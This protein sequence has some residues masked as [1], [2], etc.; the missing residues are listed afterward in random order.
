MDAKNFS[1]VEDFYQRNAYFFKPVSHDQLKPEYGLNDSIHGTPIV[2]LIEAAGL[3][4]HIDTECWTSI[5]LQTKISEI[6]KSFT[7]PDISVDEQSLNLETNAAH[8]SPR[9]FSKALHSF[10][11]W[12]LAGGMPGPGIAD[13]MAIL[14]RNVTLDRVKAAADVVRERNLHGPELEEPTSEANASR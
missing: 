9:A 13:L 11:R 7:S 5:P 1:T 8:A 10:L 2:Q 14:G 4:S 3:I 12:A 6:T